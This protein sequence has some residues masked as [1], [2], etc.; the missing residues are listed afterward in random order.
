GDARRAGAA[1]QGAPRE[2]AGPRGDDRGRQERA[3]RSCAERDGR[4]QKPGDCPGRP[5][6]QAGTTM[7][8]AV[9]G[10]L[11]GERLESGYSGSFALSFAIHAVLVVVMLFG[12]RWQSH[13][14]Q[15]VQ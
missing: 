14:P 2:I 13:P 15:T 9:L 5:A 12:V 8:A 4:S 7:S 3:L 1:R 6:G 10:A 11:P